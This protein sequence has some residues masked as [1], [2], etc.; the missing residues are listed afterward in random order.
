MNTQKK[1]EKIV[2]DLKS[3]RISQVEAYKSYVKTSAVGLE[4]GLSIA[5]AALIGY[6]ADKYWD[7]SPWGLIIGVVI[8]SIA[9]GKRL[10]VFSKSYLEKN[11]SDDDK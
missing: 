6:F 2:K 9:A 10:W 8:G 1:R 4:F 3:W 11:K 7:S 5:V